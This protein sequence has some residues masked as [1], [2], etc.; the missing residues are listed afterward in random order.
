M[1]Y[2]VNHLAQS[3]TLFRMGRFE[4]AHGWGGGQKESLPKICLTYKSHDALL[5]FC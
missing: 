4:A 1:F 2:K 5:E 3:I